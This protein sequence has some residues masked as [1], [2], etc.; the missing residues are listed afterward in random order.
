MF[1][2]NLLALFIISFVFSLNAAGW[3]DEI[4]QEITSGLSAYKA[5]Q[6]SKS[7]EHLE[8]A[9]QKIRNLKAKK[10]ETLFPKPLPGWMANDTESGAVGRMFMGGVISGSKKYLK[11]SSTVNI[12]I[13]TDNPMIGV[14]SGI[15]SNPMMLQ[16]G[17]QLGGATGQEIVRV[18][19]QKALKAW[20]PE[21]REGS[22]QMVVDNRA[23]VSIEGANCRVEDIQKYAESIDFGKIKAYIAE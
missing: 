5:K 19:D 14:V 9:A 18:K 8:F 23:L 15:L 13:T 11:N 1:K 2:K 12:T 4:E 22:M 21:N 3:A 7:A 10:I 16:M 6:Y 17:A 20:D